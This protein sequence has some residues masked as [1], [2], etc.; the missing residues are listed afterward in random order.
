[1]LFAIES[2]GKR[3]ASTRTVSLQEREPSLTEDKHTTPVLLQRDSRMFCPLSASSVLTSYTD[4]VFFHAHMR[5]KK[6]QKETRLLCVD[7][8]CQCHCAPWQQC[9]YWTTAREGLSISLFDILLPSVNSTKRVLRDNNN[10]DDNDEDILYL[11][12]LCKSQGAQNAL[13][14][15][16]THL[17]ILGRAP[18]EQ[19]LKMLSSEGNTI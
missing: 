1:M 17:N 6:Q 18:Q 5:K 19:E 7:S 4:A 15:A 11:C 10:N 3:T 14:R 9:Q 12:L 8:V 13:Q 16:N 2:G